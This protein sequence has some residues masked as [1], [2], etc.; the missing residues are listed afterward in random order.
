MIE[1]ERVSEEPKECKKNEFVIYRPDF[2]KEIR[3]AK[4]RV[5]DNGIT[6]LGR[7][8][9]IFIEIGQDYNDLFSAYSHVNLSNFVGLEYKSEKD[10]SKIVCKI[11]DLQIPDAVNISIENQLPWIHLFQ[12]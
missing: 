4:G 8:R 1:Y 10:L 12:H 5:G 3:K 11:V 7:L 9:N 2:L 6:T